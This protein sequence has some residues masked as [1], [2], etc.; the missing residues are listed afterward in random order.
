MLVPLCL[1][2]LHGKT[3]DCRFESH[4]VLFFFSQIC[5]LKQVPNG[6]EL[7]LTFLIKWMLTFLLVTKQIGKV[8]MRKTN[9]EPKDRS[10]VGSIRYQSS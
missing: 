5:V 1:E 8:R 10:I 2:R 3:R 6:V 4:Q 7:I 9:C